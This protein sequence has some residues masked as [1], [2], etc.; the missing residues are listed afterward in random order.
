MSAEEPRIEI[1]VILPLTGGW[2]E[3]GASIQ[4]SIEF[5]SSHLGLT[6]RFVF[7]YE[8]EGECDAKKALDSYK[9]LRARYAPHL[10]IVVCMNGTR[11]IKPIAKREGTLLLS[12]GFQEE[13]IFEAEGPVIN[14]ALQMN[15]EGELL[16]RQVFALGIRRLAMVRD[17]GTDAFVESMR[18]RFSADG[19]TTISL[20]VVVESPDF[21]L[22]SLIVGLKS[23][24]VE[25]LFL[26]TSP[27]NIHRLVKALREQQ[28][29]IPFLSSYGFRDMMRHNRFLHGLP[30]AVWYTFPKLSGVA[31]DF[32]GS[33]VRHFGELPKVNAL[34]VVDLLKQVAVSQERCG[35]TQEVR[36]L[37]GVLA[38]GREIEGVSGRF[39]V[40]QD[41]S[42]QREFEVVR[43][44]TG[45]AGQLMPVNGR[46]RERVRRVAN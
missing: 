28:L 10:F 17:V 26:N 23:R 34:F 46:E 27:Q 30:F 39:T 45:D 2:S 37:R 38:S 12:V 41:G 31:A 18:Q 40:R 6:E 9:S 29:S 11:A 4:K 35:T 42:I 25:G 7:R 24:S 32:E 5:A 36:C 8:D 22:R 16:A 33:F 44:G 21:D 19:L 1:G 20:D 13:E 15:D 43:T 3:W 14:Y